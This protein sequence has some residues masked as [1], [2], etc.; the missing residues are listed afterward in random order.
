MPSSKH[1]L[2]YSLRHTI[3]DE[4]DELL[5]ADWNEELQKIMAGGGE[6]TQSSR[7]FIR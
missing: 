1:L 4:A 3:I 5:D 7:G 2:T 6:L